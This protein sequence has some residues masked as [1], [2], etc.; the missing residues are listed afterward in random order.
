M[1]WAALARKPFTISLHSWSHLQWQHT[2]PLFLALL[3]YEQLEYMTTC[4]KIPMHTVCLQFRQKVDDIYIYPYLQYQQLHLVHHLAL[5]LVQ[6]SSLLHGLLQQLLTSMEISCSTSWRWQRSLLVGCLHSMLLILSST[7][8]H[9]VLDI[10]TA[11][12]LLHSPLL[13]DPSLPA[14]R[15]AQW[16]QVSMEEK[17]RQVV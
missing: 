6:P 14:S 5:P 2:W 15:S 4:V 10:S 16:K 12:E 8:V 17:Y 3:Y 11:A 1:T 9:F 7:L 13:L